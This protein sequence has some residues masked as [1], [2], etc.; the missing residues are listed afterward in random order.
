MSGAR[1]G[2]GEGS[3]TSPLTTSTARAQCHH[4]LPAATAQ[5]HRPDWTYAD[6]TGRAANEYIFF[7]VDGAK[8]M[9][10]LISE[11]LFSWVGQARSERVLI[12]LDRALANWRR[13]RVGGYRESPA[14]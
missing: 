2:S 5:V 14:G 6:Q 13:R 4:V 7:A 8:R 1:A 10:E 12:L 9:R 3:P 11:L